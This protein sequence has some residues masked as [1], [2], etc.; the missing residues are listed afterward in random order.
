MWVGVKTACLVPP[1][2]IL[3]KVLDPMPPCELVDLLFDEGDEILGEYDRSI[4]TLG[5]NPYFD[6]LFLELL[7]PVLLPVAED[8]KETLLG[9]SIMVD[10]GT[11]I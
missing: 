7:S 5:G 8:A 3:P 9:V 11:S 1:P 4:G 2:N 6:V 10:N